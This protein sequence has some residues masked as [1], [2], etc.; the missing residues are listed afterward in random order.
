MK[1]KLKNF[2]YPTPTTTPQS[3]K[4]FASGLNSG[5]GG[6]TPALPAPPHIKKNVGEGYTRF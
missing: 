1:T 3:L 6:G 5:G 2:V 4:I